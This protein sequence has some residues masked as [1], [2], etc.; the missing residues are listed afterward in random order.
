VK[1]AADPG[2]FAAIA[3][4]QEGI[5]ARAQLLTAGVSNAAIHRAVRSAAPHPHRV[6]AFAEAVK[7]GYAAAYASSS[8][9]TKRT[10]IAPSPTAPATRLVAADRTSPATKTP[11]WTVSSMYGSRPLS[12]QPR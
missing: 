4:D 9:C 7:L 11:G 2:Q 3:R 1:T 6:D 12:G 8:W 5:V 10:A